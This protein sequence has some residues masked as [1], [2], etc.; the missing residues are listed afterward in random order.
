MEPCEGALPW[1]ARASV[2]G[3]RGLNQTPGEGATVKAVY[4]WDEKVPEDGG[5]QGSRGKSWA[6]VQGWR[7]PAYLQSTQLLLG[8]RLVELSVSGFVV[9]S[10]SD[11]EGF[12]V[13]LFTSF[14]VC[15]L[16][17][18]SSAHPLVPHLRPQ[19]L[20]FDALLCTET[21]TLCP[22]A[23]VHPCFLSNTASTVPTPVHVL[24]P[25]LSMSCGWLTGA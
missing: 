22:E 9:S 3:D 14:P 4:L 5:G 25:H 6:P 10:S 16:G 19:W 12:L 7:L 17:V 23:R 18:P 2:G 21:W 24:F 1:C 15:S 8:L 20:S 11:G 13:F